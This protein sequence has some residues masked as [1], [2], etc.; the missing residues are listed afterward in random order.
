LGDELAGLLDT[1]GLRG[2]RLRVL[3]AGVEPWGPHSLELPDA[4]EAR[5]GLPLRGG[6]GAGCAEHRAVA[7]PVAV[8]GL[9]DLDG[10]V[11]H[12]VGPEHDLLHRGDLLGGPAAGAPALVLDRDQPAPLPAAD[13]AVALV[14]GVGLA[15]DRAVLLDGAVVA[16][17]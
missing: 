14:V 10:D 13:E 4:L 5:A 2:R 7:P 17:I 16:D 1:R 12:G 15:V 6:P 8:P 3:P 11:G 9:D